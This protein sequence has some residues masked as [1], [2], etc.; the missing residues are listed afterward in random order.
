MGGVKEYY[1]SET[2]SF[3]KG[4]YDR[5][6]KDFFVEGYR[7]STIVKTSDSEKP[8]NP[9]QSGKSDVYICLDK[10]TNAPKQ[11]SFY[12]NYAADNKKKKY[13]D[14]DL[15]EH[16][17]KEGYVGNPHVHEYKYSEGKIKHQLARPA[18]KEEKTL[19]ERILEERDKNE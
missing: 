18:T 9:I 12:K 14:Y 11:V 7:V 16:H 13:V 1:N 10:E 17:H 3:S 6:G 5:V 15:E 4:S 2:D 19:I 8:S